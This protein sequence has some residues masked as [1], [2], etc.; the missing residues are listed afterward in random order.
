MGQIPALKRR[1]LLVAAGLL[2][3]GCERKRELQGG[4]KGVAVERAHLLRDLPGMQGEPIGHRTRV[5]VAGAGVAGLSAAR[6][7]RMQGVE[8][9]AVLDL[10]DQAGGNARGGEIAGI[11]HPLGAHYLPVPGDDAHEVQNLLE[12]M[13]LRQRQAGRWVY[14]ERALCHSPQERLHFGGKWQDGLLPVAGV[15]EQTLAQYRQFSQLV[16]AWR[17]TGAFRMPMRWDDAAYKAWLRL[18][19]P[20]GIWLDG[21]GLNDPHLRWYL[22][23]CCRDEYGDGLDRVTAWAGIHY[24][25]SRHGFNAPGQAEEGRDQVLTWPQGNAFL[26]SHMARPLGDRLRTGMLVTRISESA[27]GVEVLA[28]DVARQQWHRWQCEA[29]VL[30]MPIHVARRV[31]EGA[32]DWLG[33]AATQ[34]RQASWVVAN[35]H[36]DAPLRDRGADVDGAAPAWDNVI[37]GSS[38]LGYVD[39]RHQTTNPLPGPTVLTWYAALG[40][41]PKA[42]AQ[43]LQAPWSDLAAQALGEMAA[44]HPDIHQR[45]TRVDITR[46]GHA[47][48]V[49]TPDTLRMVIDLQ[50]RFEGGVLR[51]KRMAMAHSDWSGYSVFEEAFTRGLHAAQAMAKV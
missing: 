47:M 35:V 39:A 36:I 24:F 26:T 15:T 19:M 13:G 51:T 20:F 41:Q 12:E 16:H 48:A 4:F 27:A 29:C 7:L 50:R 30:A 23:Y 42:R 45:A 25:A 31:V 14:D 9:F 5:L 2:A 1:S 10:E 18:S 28:L 40:S 34:V 11:A 3:A 49:P 44:A 32:P 46:C 21:Q 17:R 37:Y 6:A 38:G 22:G 43:L 33:I 8:D